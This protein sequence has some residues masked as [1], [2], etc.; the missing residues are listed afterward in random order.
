[1]EGRPIVLL[2]QIIQIHW[3]YYGIAIIVAFIF[4]IAFRRF[5]V[6]LLSG[7]L[8]LIIVLTI[9]SRPAG[10]SVKFELIPFW[11]YF[12]YFRDPGN[13]VL[14]QII[15][16]IVLFIPIGMMLEIL[17]GNLKRSII[18]G[19]LLSVVIELTQLI[20]YRG[21]CEVDDV[22][23]NTGGVLAGFMLSRLLDISKYM[24]KKGKESSK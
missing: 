2:E 9:I 15:A 6:G 14:N 16:N 21:L 23:H 11:S 7:Y 24:G 1:M 19:F 4:G 13:S 17:S 3:A 20:T 22:I 10:E 18:I 8:F 5:M 12:A